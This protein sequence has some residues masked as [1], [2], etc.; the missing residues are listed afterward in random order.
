MS[1]ETLR[2]L[3]LKNLKTLC[4][5]AKSI[6][7]Q[8]RDPA[9]ALSH[10]RTAVIMRVPGFV[11]KGMELDLSD[12]LM[13]IRITAS[14]KWDEFQVEVFI[15]GLL[16]ETS[17]MGIGLKVKNMVTALGKTPKVTVTLANGNIIWHL[18]MGSTFGL[19]VINTKVN[20]KH[21]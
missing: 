17:T 12:L 18:D 7:K 10:I 5:S 1:S 2:I 19:M 15:D 9:T 21:R 11:T 14:M 20:G 16:M 4:I 6:Y 13:E 3:L 8:T